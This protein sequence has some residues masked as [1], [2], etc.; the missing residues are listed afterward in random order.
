M[1]LLIFMV[2]LYTLSGMGHCLDGLAFI[3]SLAGGVTLYL[4][5]YTLINGPYAPAEWDE[6]ENIAIVICGIVAY[7]EAH[8][9]TCD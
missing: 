6:A 5:N 9:W 8:L 4:A 1:L 7:V 3:L 2:H